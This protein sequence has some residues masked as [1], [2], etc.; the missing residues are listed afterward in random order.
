MSHGLRSHFARST[1]AEQSQVVLAMGSTLS[2]CCSGAEVKPFGTKAP[3]LEFGLAGVDASL[4]T[5]KI[6]PRPPE[7]K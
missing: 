4:K 1:S 6:R 7:T 5:E 2:A 3:R